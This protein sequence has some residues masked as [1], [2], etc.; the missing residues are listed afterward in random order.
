[1]KA[2]LQWEGFVLLKYKILREFGSVTDILC[3]L[4]KKTNLNLHFPFQWPQ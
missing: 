2:I 1:M 3:A 4:K